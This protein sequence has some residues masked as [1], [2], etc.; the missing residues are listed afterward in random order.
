[1]TCK[2]LDSVEITSCKT[3][4]FHKVVWQGAVS[5][6]SSLPASTRRIKFITSGCEGFVDDEHRYYFANFVRLLDWRAIG[7]L[8][9]RRTSPP[10]LEI[11]AESAR[12]HACV[13]FQHNPTAQAE[14]LENF[15]D[16]LCNMTTFL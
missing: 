4:I 16:R 5:M 15:S 12:G 11:G 3:A 13:G 14:V 9:E 8:L 2:L 10:V 7:R 6:L 1:M